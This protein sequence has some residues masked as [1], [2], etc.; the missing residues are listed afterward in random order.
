M[1]NSEKFMSGDRKSQN[2]TGRS[3]LPHPSYPKPL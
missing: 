2:A 1:N 3:T